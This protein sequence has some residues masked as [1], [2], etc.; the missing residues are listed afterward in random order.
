MNFHRAFFVL[1]LVAFYFFCNYKRLMIFTSDVDCFF[2]E[3]SDFDFRFLKDKDGKVTGIQREAYGETS[4]LEK[5][6]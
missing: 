4:I 5:I 6:S 2:I 3:A 1:D